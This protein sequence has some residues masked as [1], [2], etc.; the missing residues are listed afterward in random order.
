[1][2]NVNIST[3]HLIWNEFQQS[4]KIEKLPND[5]NIENSLDINEE[6]ILCEIVD[7]D[8]SLNLQVLSVLPDDN[9]DLTECTIE[10]KKFFPLNINYQS[11]G[12]NDET[13]PEVTKVD[14][15]FYLLVEEILKGWPREISEEM[16]CVKTF[17]NCQTIDQGCVL[18]G[19]RILYF[20]S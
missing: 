13:L 5:R 9:L 10:E 20:A 8:S 7:E 2:F 15:S 18:Y 4:K 11:D 3:V 12:S 6:S 14:P 16:N 17:A 19:N 1:M